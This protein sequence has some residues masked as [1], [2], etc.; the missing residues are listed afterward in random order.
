MSRYA[1]YA[2][3]LTAFAP[4][5]FIYAVVSAVEGEICRAVWLALVV[6]VLVVIC[7]EL[8]DFTRN[9]VRSRSF[10]ADG[11]ESVDSEVFGFVLIYLLPL[12]TRDLADYN[13][14]AWA[15]IAVLFCAVVAIGQ[16]Y[17][18]NPL[19]TVL[20]YHFY[21]VREEK[22]I[23]HILITRRRLYSARAELT[24]ARLSDFVLLDK[25]DPSPG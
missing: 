10:H 15:L 1:K 4:A 8:L 23:P 16:G 11:V 13:W 12:I 9:D 2:L 19:L 6:G 20:G 25:K 22:G 18:F 3:A 21:R 7:L 14:A 24:V 17:H 5:L